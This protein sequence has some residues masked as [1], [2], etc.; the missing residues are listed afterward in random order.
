MPS[1]ESDISLQIPRQK[2]YLALTDTEFISRAIPGVVSVEQKGEHA[3]G[4]T[5]D[6]K[7]GLIHRR[8]SLDVIFDF[9]QDEE[10]TFEAHSKEVDLK[11]RV[12]LSEP[13]SMSTLMKVELT[14]EASGPL[15]HVV[16]N[17]VSDMMKHVPKTLGDMLGEYLSTQQSGN[18]V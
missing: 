17:I 18:A 8:L 13:E 2:V 9:R 15:K 7:K 4:W 12:S 10:I 11:G 6:V 5:V 16:N 14:Y 3:A 1:I